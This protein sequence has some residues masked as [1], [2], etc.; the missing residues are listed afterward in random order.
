MRNAKKRIIA[1]LSA[2]MIAAGMGIAVPAAAQAETYSASCAGTHLK[3]V[4]VKNS[5]GTVIGRLG[6]YRDG[7]KFCAIG[8]KAGGVYGV[9]TFTQLVIYSSIDYG[10]DD[11]DFKYRTDAI[12][13]NAR[14]GS[15]VVA[16]LIVR[17]KAGNNQWNDI[18]TCE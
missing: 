14:P 15:C 5:T 9:P 4:S 13:I 10:K 3:T 17:T 7:T 2:A 11:G 1:G 6:M 18:N 12:T 8:V 16:Q